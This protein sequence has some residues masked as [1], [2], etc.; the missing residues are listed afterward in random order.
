MRLKQLLLGLVYTVVAHNNTVPMN[1]LTNSLS[2]SLITEPE[3]EGS[4]VRVAAF[5]CLLVQRF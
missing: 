1:N 3:P 5:F 2:I 4:V